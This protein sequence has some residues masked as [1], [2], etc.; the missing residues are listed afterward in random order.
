M[1][2]TIAMIKLG[3]LKTGDIVK[4]VD[5]GVEREGAVV[6]ISHEDHQALVDNGVQEFWCLA[7]NCDFTNLYLAQGYSTSPF[8]YNSISNVNQATGVVTGGVAVIGS[9]PMCCSRISRAASTTDAVAPI[10]RG[11]PVIA[12]R[13]LFAIVRASSSLAVRS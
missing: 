13:T 12:S 11:S 4:V 1:I 3:E 10:E 9:E 8:V 5:D 2:K 7:F 6:E